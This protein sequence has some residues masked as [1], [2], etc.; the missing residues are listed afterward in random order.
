MLQIAATGGADEF[1]VYVLPTKP[2]SP[3]ASP[4]NKHTFQRGILFHKGRPVHAGSSTGGG[5]I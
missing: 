3:G 5:I 4:V 2:I 1:E